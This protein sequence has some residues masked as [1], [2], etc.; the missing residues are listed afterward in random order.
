MTYGPGRKAAAAAAAASA[1][2]AAATTVNYFSC[3]WGNKERSF[4]RLRVSV[5]N[6]GERV[7]DF[8]W[9]RCGEKSLHLWWANAK[10]QADHV[11]TY[12]C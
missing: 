7:P 4:D 3:L 6:C 2:A 9:L 5:H 1:A 8:R 10:G 11:E 12:H